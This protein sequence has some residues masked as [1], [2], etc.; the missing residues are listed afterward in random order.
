[1]RLQAQKL[2]YSN[3]FLLKIQGM[4]SWTSIG[5]GDW[6]SRHPSLQVDLTCWQD[7]RITTQIRLVI[8]N[9]T[10][11]QKTDYML[12]TPDIWSAVCKDYKFIQIFNVETSHDREMII[13]VLRVTSRGILPCR[14]RSLWRFRWCPCALVL[15]SSVNSQQNSCLL[16]ME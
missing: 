14:M 5:T 2:W 9:E 3:Y 12:I 4:V 7:G 13:A 1:M 8:H 11:P 16:Q 15:H 6:R 10:L